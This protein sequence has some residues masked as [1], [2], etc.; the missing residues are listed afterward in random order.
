MSLEND[1]VQVYFLGPSFRFLYSYIFPVAGSSTPWK[2]MVPSHMALTSRLACVRECRGYLWGGLFAGGSTLV[3]YDTASS[4]LGGV[5]GSALYRGVG[6][7][8]TTLV[9]LLVGVG[10]GLCVPST[11]KM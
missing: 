11:A 7:D 8:V 6:N 5:W 2:A 1:L 9:Q 10:V 3:S 4:T